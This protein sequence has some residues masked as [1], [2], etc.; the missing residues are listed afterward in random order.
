MP[1]P[2]RT[3]DGTLNMAAMSP[4]LLAL[5]A[6]VPATENDFLSRVEEHA[7][8]ALNVQIAE[9][10][11]IPSRERKDRHRRRHADVDADHAA[12][13]SLGELSRM[14]SATGENAGAV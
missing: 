3:V 6:A 5:V 8:G 14:P 10:R 13:Y 7:F 1:L 11:L 4:P 12:L 2:I 9:E